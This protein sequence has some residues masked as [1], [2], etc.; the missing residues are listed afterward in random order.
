[1]HHCPYALHRTDAR[2]EQSDKGA[3]LTA[4]AIEIWA[5][6]ADRELRL[7]GLLAD[8]A[9]AAHEEALQWV[10]WGHWMLLMDCAQA[11]TAEIVQLQQECSVVRRWSPVLVEPARIY[12]EFVWCRTEW[13]SKE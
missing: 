11:W 5:D 6:P 7:V 4:L 13:T 10:A 2:F 8:L 1:M 9:V 3:C 12:Q